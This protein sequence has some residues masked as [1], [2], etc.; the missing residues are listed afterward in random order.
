MRTNK[1]NVTLWP[2]GSDGKEVRQVVTKD[3]YDIDETS[4]GYIFGTLDNI[5]HAGQNHLNPLPMRSVSVGDIIE[6]GDMYFI[7]AGIGFRKVEKGY[8]P[9]QWEL[10]GIVNNG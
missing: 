9:T 6:F 4:A 10:M 5:F 2:F 1:F 7:V 3:T 8:V